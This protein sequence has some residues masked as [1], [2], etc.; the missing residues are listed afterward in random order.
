MTVG[1]GHLAEY[2]D[3]PNCERLSKGSDIG[4]M[5]LDGELTAT[6]QGN[7]LPK[8]L[9]M[10]TLV[11][12]ARNAA[13]A[14]F[15]REQ[16]VPVNHMFAVHK[17][18]SGNRPDLIREIFRMLVESRVLTEGSVPDPFPPIGPDANRKGLQLAIDWAFEQKIIL[19]KMSVDELFEETTGALEHQVECIVSRTAAEQVGFRL[20]SQPPA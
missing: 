8:E 9:R 16:V 13:K 6:L 20:F 7:D 1:E 3:P 11:P 15:E 17:D 12:E 5:M 10:Q 18:L 2:T 19:A 4:Q 14:W